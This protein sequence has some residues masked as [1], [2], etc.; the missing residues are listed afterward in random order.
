MERE[1]EIESYLAELSSDWNVHCSLVTVAVCDCYDS[2]N[3]DVATL[4][5][6]ETSLL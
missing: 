6:R 2:P 1:R 5:R 3:Y 4:T